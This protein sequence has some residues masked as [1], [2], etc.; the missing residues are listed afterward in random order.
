MVGTAQS[1][2]YADVMTTPDLLQPA[3]QETHGGVIWY[4]DQP[5]FALRRVSKTARTLAGD[6]WL[7]LRRS[8]AYSVTAVAARNIFD[9]SAFLALALLAVVGVWAFESGRWRRKD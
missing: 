1:E 7:G 9:N 5:D 2:E 3:V 4:Q 8:E 6:D